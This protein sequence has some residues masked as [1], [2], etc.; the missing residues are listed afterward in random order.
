MGF[1]TIVLPA[2]DCTCLCKDEMS[3]DLILL[4]KSDDHKSRQDVGGDFR[5]LETIY[6]N[7][8]AN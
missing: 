5:V 8:V 3:C 1:K 7:T 6:T 2:F 4:I